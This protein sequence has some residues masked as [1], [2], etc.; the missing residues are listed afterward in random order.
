MVDGK[1]GRSKLTTASV[2]DIERL[3]KSLDRKLSRFRTVLDE[4]RETGKSKEKLQY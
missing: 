1:D 3:C 2:D 4:F